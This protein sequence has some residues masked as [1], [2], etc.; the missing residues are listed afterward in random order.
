MWDKRWIGWGHKDYGK[1]RLHLGWYASED[2][3]RLLS[4]HDEVDLL[5]SGLDVRVRVRDI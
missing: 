3:V 1:E 5:F 4:F 2:M